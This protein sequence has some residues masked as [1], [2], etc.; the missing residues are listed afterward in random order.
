MKTIVTLF[1]SFLFSN[2]GHAQV[3]YVPFANTLIKGGTEFD[4]KV[5][6]FN[7][8]AVVDDDGKAIALTADNTYQR[9]DFDLALKYALTNYLELQVGM[10]GRFVQSKVTQDFGSGEETINF[11]NNGPV[12]SKVGFKYSFKEVERMKYALE[13]YYSSPLHSNKIYV[14]GTEPDFISLGDDTRAYGVGLDVYFKTKSNNIL[15][16]R[17]MYRS[18]GQDLSHEIYTQLQLGLVWSYVSIYAGSEA[19]FSRNNSAYTDDPSSRPLTFQGNSGSFNSV[20]RQWTSPYLGMNFALGQ[21]WKMQLQYAQTINGRSTDLSQRVLVGFSRRSELPDDEYAKKNQKFKQYRVEGTVT[22]LSSSRK[23]AIVDKG[24]VDGLRKGMK[25]DFYFFDFVGGN[26]LIAKGVV[27][28]SK[29]SRALV[30]ITRKFSRKRVESGTVIRADEVDQQLIF[31][32]TDYN[33]WLA[34]FNK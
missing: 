31:T 22:K 18:P 4:F 7:T 10:K 32:K 33:T 25:V 34:I 24:L 21:K 3:S 16:T 1:F 9:A 14:A 26:T 29:A 15:E 11:N 12:A 17:V 20:N 27:I 8:T 19:I 2:F 23:V 30:K 13:G 5:E 6:Y 28:Q